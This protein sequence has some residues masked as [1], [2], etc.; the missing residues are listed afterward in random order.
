MPTPT[1][2]ANGLSW[3]DYADSKVAG[4]CRSVT[5][6]AAQCRLI[7]TTDPKDDAIAEETEH[8]KARIRA[9]VELPFRMIKRQVGYVKVHYRGPAKNAAQLHTLFALSNLGMA[10]RKLRATQA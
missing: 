4:I 6:R 1:G 8:V 5:P 7:D 10:G 2:G 3:P 9:E